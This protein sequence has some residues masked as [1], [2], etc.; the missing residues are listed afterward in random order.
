M[1]LKV[2]GNWEKYEDLVTSFT[3]IKCSRPSFLLET[4]RFDWIKQRGLSRRIKTKKDPYRTGKGILYQ[5]GKGWLEIY[6][7]RTRIM[8]KHVRRFLL[9]LPDRTGPRH[10]VSESLWVWLA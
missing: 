6:G 4:Q 10:R 5:N 9:F 1:S 3:A 8:T 7:L 2:N